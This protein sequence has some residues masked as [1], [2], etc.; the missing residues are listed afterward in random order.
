MRLIDEVF[1]DK[2]KIIDSDR[3]IYEKIK[4]RCKELINIYPEKKQCLKTI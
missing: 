1:A 2:E 3:Y 4:R